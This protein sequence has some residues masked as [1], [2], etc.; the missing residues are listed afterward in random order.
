MQLKNL[1]WW[2]CPTPHCLDASGLDAVVSAQLTGV[3]RAANDFG[4]AGARANT[5]S[6]QSDVLRNGGGKGRWSASFGTRRAQL[7]NAAVLA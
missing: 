6:A 4:C 3:Q 7:G 2:C 5:A 1:G